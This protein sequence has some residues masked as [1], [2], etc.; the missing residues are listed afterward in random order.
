MDP[1]AYLRHEDP[2]AR[3]YARY[4]V[5]REE[6]E[7][8]PI[9]ALDLPPQLPAPPIPQEE[10]P[11]QPEPPQERAELSAERIELPKPQE[12][13]VKFEPAE[14]GAVRRILELYA[15][16][17]TV[18]PPIDWRIVEE[19]Y[20]AAGRSPPDYYEY[21]ERVARAVAE[22]KTLP[23]EDRLNAE[24]YLLWREI[25][26]GGREAA[27]RKAAELFGEPVDEKYIQNRAKRF[28]DR[29]GL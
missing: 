11:R 1:W 5:R 13:G 12:L 29:Y 22:K 17:P 28:L 16:D 6:P 27:L 26:A 4:L 2:S 24:A 23:A 7:P 14:P 18:K 8:L 10:P 21:M 3:V 9:T 25:E 20:K 19:E 15:E